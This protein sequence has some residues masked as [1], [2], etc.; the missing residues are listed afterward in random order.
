MDLTL[1]GKMVFLLLFFEKQQHDDNDFG[2]STFN[3]FF[4]F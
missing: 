4:H 2:L 1:A 3:T